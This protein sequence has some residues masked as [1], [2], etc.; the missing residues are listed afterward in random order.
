MENPRAVTAHERSGFVAATR[1]AKSVFL[2]MQKII[3]LLVHKRRLAPRLRAE[4]GPERK[5]WAAMLV[6]AICVLFGCAPQQITRK[7]SPSEGPATRAESLF[8]AADYEAA[9][10]EYLRLADSA[11]P[12]QAEQFRLHAADAFQRAGILER[13]RQ[14]LSIPAPSKSDRSLRAWRSL[15]Q[16]EIAL[17]DQ[18]IEDA[19]AFLQRTS[20]EDLPQSH[21]ARY[22]QAEAQAFHHTKRFLDEAI[23]RVALEPLLDDIDEIVENRFRIWDA[24]SATSTSA[25]NRR[26]ASADGTLAGWLELAILAQTQLHRSNAF[27]FSVAS[28]ESRYQNHPAAESI[29]PE[30]LQLS[31]ELAVNPRQIALLL[32]LNGRFSAAGAAVR[33]GFLAAWYTARAPGKPEIRV[34][35]A[36]VSNIASAYELAVGEGANVIVGPLEKAAVDALAA[37]GVLPV[38]TLALN[39]SSIEEDERITEADQHLHT[40]LYQFGLPPEDEARQ[41]AERAWFDGRVRALAIT[42]KGSWG[43]RVYEAFEEHWRRLG[44]EVLEHDEYSSTTSDYATPVKSLLN[45]DGSELRASELRKLLRTDVKAEPRRR[46]DADFVFMPAYPTQARQLRPQL[47]FHR[48]VDLPAYSLSYAY[49]GFVDPERDGDMN[50]VAFGDMPWILSPAVET[51]PAYTAVIRNWNSEFQ[52][53]ARLFALGV[54]AYRLIPELGRLRVQRF[55]RFDGVTGTLSMDE[56]GHLHRQLI[57]AKFVDGVPKLID[58][59]LSSVTP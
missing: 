10:E 15:L 33:D 8:Q 51:D 12:A 53:Y 17:Q 5:A 36:Q 3:G 16:A 44:G 32:P 57:W 50:G 11:E 4:P 26:L 39:Q 24:L 1:P 38:T 20:S 52:A 42:P 59:G 54:D 49:T 22:Y 23:A 2:W 7:Q 56:H 14:I 41:V 46:Q 18:H 45:I 27:S 9:G 35:D 25:L 40:R 29:V 31:K 34:Y 48:A 37:R 13:V 55:A 58:T 47:D 21:R 43:E 30:L 28:W 19:L 6:L